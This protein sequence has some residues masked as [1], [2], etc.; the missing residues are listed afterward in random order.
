MFLTG[1]IRQQIIVIVLIWKAKKTIFFPT[2]FFFFFLVVLPNTGNIFKSA[3]RLI[4]CMKTFLCN[5][6]GG[7]CPSVETSTDKQNI[8]LEDDDGQT[9]ILNR[10]QFKLL[11][12]YDPDTGMLVNL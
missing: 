9:V 12:T 11:Q 8:I 4:V 7:C 2:S 6:P 5:K 1:C 10:E 3:S